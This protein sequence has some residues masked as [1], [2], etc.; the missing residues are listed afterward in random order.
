MGALV[1]TIQGVFDLETGEEFLAGRSINHLMR[2]ED[3][4]WAVDDDG[5]LWRGE[6]RAAQS[7]DATFNCVLP[8]GHGVWLGASSARLYWW[9]EEGLAEDLA[10]AEAPGRESWHTPWGGPP[11]VRSM[12]FGPDGI[13]YVN[14]HVGGILFY[15]DSGVTPTLDID[16]DIHQVV[17]HPTRPAHVLAA[18]AWG[19]AVSTNGHDYDFRTDGLAHN[20]CR[21]VAV[22][23]A[24]VIVSAARGPSGGDSAIYRG[25]LDGGRLRRCEHGLPPSFEGNLDTHC[26]AATDTG[27]VAVNGSSAW[28]SDD[29]GI[30]WRVER[31]DL[32]R[33]TCLTA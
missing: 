16:A 20:Y 10:F 15:D 11:D 29:D 7:E 13:L 24:T 5:G 28:R 30:T 9:D 25:E 26:L 17:A 1:G 32:P 21:A 19:L 31:S 4:W 12:A 22:R 2:D 14:V 33:V 27:F 3:G 18:S 23:D 6:D 8:A